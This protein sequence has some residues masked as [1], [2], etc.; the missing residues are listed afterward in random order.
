M[1]GKLP[2]GLSLSQDS[3]EVETIALGSFLWLWQLQKTSFQARQ[4][5]AVGMILL[6]LP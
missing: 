3:T 5:A 2:P 4:C 6:G 1:T